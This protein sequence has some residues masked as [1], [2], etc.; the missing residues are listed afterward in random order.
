[1][2]KLIIIPACARLSGMYGVRGQCILFVH[3]KNKGDLVEAHI[4]TAKKKM[5]KHYNYV[6]ELAISYYC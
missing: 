5:I 6:V 4:T 2:N 3:D 1:M